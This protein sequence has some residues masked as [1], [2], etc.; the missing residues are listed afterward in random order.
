MSS[1]FGMNNIEFTAQG[2]WRLAE[3]LGMMC[4]SF[5]LLQRTNYCSG[6]LLTLDAC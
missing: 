3:Q 4:K 1:I 2:D 6:D 5:L